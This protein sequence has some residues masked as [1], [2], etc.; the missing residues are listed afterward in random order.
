MAYWVYENWQAGPHKAVVHDGSCGY[1]KDGRGRSG[2]GTNPAYGRWHGPYATLDEAQTAATGLQPS[3][4]KTHT[5]CGM[6]AWSAPAAEPVIG[7]RSSK[8]S[9][10]RWTLE[11]RDADFERSDVLLLG[12]TAEK[13]DHPAEAQDLYCSPR[14][15]K[16][17]LYA[18]AT[19]KLWAIISAKHG[20]LMPDELIEPYDLSLDSLSASERSQ[21]A[22]R[23]VAQLE[24]ALGPL[25]G[26]TFELLASRLYGDPL[27]LLLAT[28]GARLVRPL[29]HVTLFQELSWYE[30]QLARLND[31]TH[32]ETAPASQSEAG[33][34]GVS[35]RL[36]K[37]FMDGA[38]DLS[39]RP[40]AETVGWEGVPEV[41]A[42]ARLRECGATDSQV[43]L[44]L[45]LTCAMDRARDA[46]RL[47]ASATGL[48]LEEPALFD[49][50][51]VVTNRDR[52][53]ELLRSSGVSQRH[54]RDL[55][56]WMTIAGSL[57]A[58]SS[59]AIAET[60]FEGSGDARVLLR[61][62]CQSSASGA[63]CYPMIRGPKIGPLWVRMLAYPGR[64]GLSSIDVIPVAVDVHVR[65]A[66]ERLGIAET[67]GFDIG[68]ARPLIQQAWRDEAATHGVAGP[69]GLGDSC[70]AL[71]PALW[72]F[73]KH[74]CSYCETA[75]E[76]IPITEVCE[77]CRL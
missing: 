73:G 10:T 67:Q 76:R 65:R 29:R 33:P 62:R 54:T 37:A 12:C 42:A 61:E 8:P 44:F 38:F 26:C 60:V 69:D 17:R 31:K 53:G 49:P 52:V 63:A 3:E 48:F 5:C 23:I 34:E 59:S 6:K 58:R 46:G 36:S 72:F 32:S 15:A 28:R 11:E 20:L 51:Y 77:R 64:A 13:L 22:E 68:E 55:D 39:A 70:A 27:E 1:C 71:D 74:G 57:A 47:W 14:F 7:R 24:E 9:T 43:R 18:K 45:T 16:R 35:W 21:W 56:A 4:L 19:G 2:K 50:A 75:G 41:P 40:Q 66:S 25:D 30:A